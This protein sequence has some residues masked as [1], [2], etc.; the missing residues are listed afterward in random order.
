M[1]VALMRRDRVVVVVRPLGEVVGKLV[2]GCVWGGVLKV[3]DGE[4][5]MLVLRQEEWRGFVCGADPEDVAVLRLWVVVVVAVRASAKARQGPASRPA[6]TE[7][8]GG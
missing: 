3:D 5:L 1:R 4:L 7:R 8:L 6:G 2:A